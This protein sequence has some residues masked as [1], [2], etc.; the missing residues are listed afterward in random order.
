MIYMRGQPQDYDDLGG[1]GLQGLGLDGR[2]ALLQARGK[3]RARRRRLARRR[4]A[5]SCQRSQLPESGGR[6]LRRGGCS[7]GVPAQ[8]RFQWRARRKA[9]GLIRCSRRMAADTMPRGPISQ[10]AP[11]PNLT[12]FSE[13][14]ARRIVF[15]GQAGGRRRL[16]AAAARRRGSR[17]ARDHRV[18]RRVRLAATADGLGRGTGRAAEADYGIEVVCDSPKSAPTFRTIATHSRTC[19]PR[20]PACSATTPVRCWRSVGELSRFLRHG[21]GLLTSNGA[22]AGGFIRSRPDIDR[23]DL[24][25]HF[26]IRIVDDHTR[27]RHFTTGMSLHVCALRPKS[28]GSVR[29]ASPDIAKA[30][31]IDP[32]FLADP[33]DL[34]TLVRGVEI[35][36]TILAQPAL[37]PYGGRYIYGTGARR[38]RGAAQL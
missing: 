7:G 4:R 26:C 30:P 23:P 31:L 22:E 27:K 29:L 15:E 19:A 2:A 13:S 12:I 1:A 36:Q 32:N 35:V 14:Q 3:Q 10:A 24:Q 6:R 25:L 11:Q 18:R 16:F 37:A 33:E 9:L 28:R 20:D 5:A 38:P 21:S 8:C 34:E 17:A